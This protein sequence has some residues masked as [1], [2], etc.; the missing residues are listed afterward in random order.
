MKTITIQVPD[1]FQIPT[2][3]K[4]QIVE[5]EEKKEPVIRTYQDLINNAVKINVGYWIELNSNIHKTCNFTINSEED[6]GV[7]ASE[8]VAKSML[9]MAQISQLMPYYGGEITDEEWKDEDLRK[10]VIIKQG[11]KILLI[12]MYGVHEFLAFHTEEQCN[13]F[14]KWNLDLVKDYLMID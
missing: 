6:K 4:I 5:K 14:L 7:A 9:A 1:N 10:Y 13:E 8:K 2:N 11:G 12:A 3:Y